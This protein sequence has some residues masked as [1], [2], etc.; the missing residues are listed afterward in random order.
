MNNCNMGE[1]LKQV[2]C[3]E[4]NGLDVQDIGLTYQNKKKLKNRITLPKLVTCQAA[5]WIM[6]TLIF[7][8]CSINKVFCC[9][10]VGHVHKNLVIFIW[11]Y[12]F[13]L[14]NKSWNYK[15]FIYF[16]LFIISNNCGT[17]TGLKLSTILYAV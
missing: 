3:L 8:S 12:L 11:S 1:T 5:R 15:L 10:K 6:Y 16:L 9:R 17:P 13:G 4:Q 14:V 7:R 2:Q